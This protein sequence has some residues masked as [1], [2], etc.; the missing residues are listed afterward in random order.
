MLATAKIMKKNHQ[1]GFKYLRL[2][3]AVL[4]FLAL[5]FHLLQDHTFKMATLT[6]SRQ[7]KIVYKI[8]WFMV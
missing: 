6:N 7:N 4:I 3:G 8:T 1:Y 2:N 5:D